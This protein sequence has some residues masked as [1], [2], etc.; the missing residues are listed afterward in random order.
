[1]TTEYD[2]AVSVIAENPDATK[3]ALAEAMYARL[4]ASTDVALKDFLRR[5][6]I[7]GLANYMGAT[8][9]AMEADAAPK[10]SYGGRPMTSTI[11]V[12]GQL[13]LWTACSPQEFV[14]AV[15]REDA[16]VTGR[17]ESN[18]VR[19]AFVD[20][21]KASSDL[22]SLPTLA[23]AVAAAGWDIDALDL[24]SLEASP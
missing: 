18:R 20:Q 9:A 1:M 19:T 12:N 15:L 16:V 4:T 8:K 5:Q 23:D 7:R 3:V 21:L 22:M 10:V 14:D 13:K 2:L 11:A 17:A 6:T 24:D